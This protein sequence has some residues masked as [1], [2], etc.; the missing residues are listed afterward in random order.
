[1]DFTVD[2]QGVTGSAP[3]NHGHGTH[4]AGTI[5]GRAVDGKRQESTD[6]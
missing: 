2:E 4:V 5:F 3:D 1:M 6:W